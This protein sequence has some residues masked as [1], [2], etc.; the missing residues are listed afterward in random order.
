MSLHATGNQSYANDLQTFFGQYQE[1]AGTP[2]YDINYDNVYWAANL[3]AANLTGSG[4]YHK[5]VQVM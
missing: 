5:Q 2:T 1:N 3:L 4:S